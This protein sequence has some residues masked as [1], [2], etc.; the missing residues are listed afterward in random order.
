MTY[1]K[2]VELVQHSMNSIEL[3]LEDILK[4][5]HQ[6]DDLKARSKE[7]AFRAKDESRVISIYLKDEEFEQS[8]CDDFLRK[9][10]HLQ[11][12]VSNLISI[13][14]EQ[15]EAFRS[16]HFELRIDDKDYLSHACAKIDVQGF[17][18]NFKVLASFYLTNDTRALL[19]SCLYSIGTKHKVDLRLYNHDSSISCNCGTAMMKIKKNHFSCDVDSESVPLFIEILFVSC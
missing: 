10:R 7:I 3:Y 17:E 9:V 2:K 13:K 14:N 19:E 12:R 15:H 8:L 18:S 16:N 4:I 6:I 5:Q 11:D 1:I